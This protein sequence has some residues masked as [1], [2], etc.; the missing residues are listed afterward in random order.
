VTSRARLYGFPSRLAEGDLDRE[1]ERDGECI[2]LV[3]VSV[4]IGES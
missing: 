1:R 2:S 4:V 3:G